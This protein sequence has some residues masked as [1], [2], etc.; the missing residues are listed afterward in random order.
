LEMPEKSA[1]DQIHMFEQMNSRNQLSADSYERFR[2]TMVTRFDRVFGNPPWGGVLKGPLAPVYDTVKKQRFA[3][4]FPAAAKGKYDVYGLFMERSLQ[5]LTTGGRMALLT[6]DTYLDKE[7]A[8]ELRKLL[9]SKTKLEYIVDMNPFGQLFFNAMNAPCVT[10]VVNTQKELDGACLSVMSHPP[11]DFKELGTQERREKVVETIRE[12]LAKLGTKKQQANHLFTNAAR[13]ELQRLRET[14]PD[15]WD[16]SGSAGKAAFPSNWF[17]AAELLEMRQGVT[18]GGC[19]DVFLMDEKK[20]GFLGL[21]DALVRKAIKS[22]ELERWRVDWKDRM[23][24]YPYHATERAFEPAFSIQW[25]EIE[26][27]TLKKRLTRRGMNDALD[28]NQQIDGRETD[29]VKESGINNDSVK[30]LFKHRVSLGLIK[31][32]KAAAYLLVNYER[33]ESRV[34]KKKNIRAFNRRWYEYL[35]P[36]DGNIMLAKPRILSPTLIRS[37]RFVLDDVGYL[38]D[39]ACLMIQ[40]TKKTDCTWREFQKAMANAL[41]RKMSDDDLLLYCLRYCLAFLNSKYA[42]ERLTTGH[43]PTPKGSYTITEE[44]LKEIPIPAPV[45]SRFL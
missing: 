25:D 42:Q 19:L 45:P 27:E 36:R 9:A 38:S 4:I 31:Y 18:P 10:V 15:R 11:K 5:L 12:V 30:E 41:R 23:L 21:E 40:P 17:T 22:K 26:D 44:Y 7:W 28:F 8:R 20:A 34:F 2:R 29:I 16:L 3:R 35:W 13:I 32:P 39:H 37:V 6:Q 14:A 33:L 24:F 43:R 1:E